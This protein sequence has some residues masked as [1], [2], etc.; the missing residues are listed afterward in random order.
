MIPAK[1]NFLPSHAAAVPR[2]TRFDWRYEKEKG[3]VSTTWKVIT[4]GGGET[5]HGWV[6]HHYRTTEHDL[7]L[8]GMEYIT[9]R[10]KMVVAKGKEFKIAWP[11]T[12]LFLC[13]RSPRIRP[14]ARRFWQI[15]LPDG[16]MSY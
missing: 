15:L 11:F 16:E 6:P 5:L 14:F 3:R 4:E 2:D 7:K 13:F 12:G 1:L 10:G 9:R 8:T